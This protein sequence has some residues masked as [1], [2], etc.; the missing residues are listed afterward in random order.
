LVNDQRVSDRLS[1]RRVRGIDPVAGERDEKHQPA[2][3]GTRTPAPPPTAISITCWCHV[4]LLTVCAEERNPP[5]QGGLSNDRF[6]IDDQ[7]GSHDMEMSD[8]LST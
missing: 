6:V 8:T 5:S 4:G 1:G 2:V 3:P 7:L